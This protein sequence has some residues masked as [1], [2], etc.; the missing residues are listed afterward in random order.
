[1]GNIWKFLLL[2]VGCIIVVALITLSLRVSKKGEGDTEKNLVQYSKVAS[3]AEDIDLKIYDNVEVKGSEIVDLIKK[4]N[5]NE[6]LSIVVDTNSGVSTAYI[7]P[8]LAIGVTAPTVNSGIDFS[9]LPTAKSNSNYINQ[10]GMFHS[11]VYYD[12]NDVVACVWFTQQ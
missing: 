8:C 10:A 9:A 11:T 1:M 6:Y 4:Y 3:D 5:D 12:A 7:N 2:A